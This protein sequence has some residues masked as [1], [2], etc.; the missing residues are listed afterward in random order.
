[1]VAYS[2]RA[3]TDNANFQYN[4]NLQGG[5]AGGHTPVCVA[6][7]GDTCVELHNVQRDLCTWH[8]IPGMGSDTAFSK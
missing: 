8:D 5:S 3:F 4:N 2:R 7:A 6:V 1:M